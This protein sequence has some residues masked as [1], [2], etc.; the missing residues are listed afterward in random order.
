MPHEVTFNRQFYKPMKLLHVSW[1]VMRTYIF[2]LNETNYLRPGVSCSKQ[3]NF[4]AYVLMLCLQ[5][6]GKILHI[7]FGRKYMYLKLTWN[8]K[9]ALF[10]L[11]VLVFNFFCNCYAICFTPNH[12]SCFTIRQDER[13]IETCFFLKYEFMSALTWYKI[14]VGPTEL[15]RN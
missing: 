14:D 8:H 7:H 13:F 5:S 3:S 15:F 9:Y 12:Y 11:D 6:W 1:L 4:I 2:F 10:T